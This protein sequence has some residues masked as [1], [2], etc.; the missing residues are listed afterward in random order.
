MAI[1]DVSRKYDVIL[2]N[3]VYTSLESKRVYFKLL[4]LN[5]IIQSILEL[6]HNLVTQF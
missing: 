5:L 1:F 3:R 4:E 2:R 6:L